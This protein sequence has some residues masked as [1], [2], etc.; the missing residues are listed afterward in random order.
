MDDVIEQAAR[1]IANVTWTPVWEQLS[2]DHR[3]ECRSQAQ[4]LAQAGLIVGASPAAWR[5]GQRVRLLDRHD[6]VIERVLPRR[7]VLRLDGVNVSNAFDEDF[8]QPIEE[9]Q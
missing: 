2:E 1:V 5:E 7:V 3:R 9:E 8:I 4:A 6:G